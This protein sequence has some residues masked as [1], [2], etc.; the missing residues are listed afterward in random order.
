M[1]KFHLNGN[2]EEVKVDRR[3]IV[4]GGIFVPYYYWTDVCD[5]CKERECNRLK[6]QSK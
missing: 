2:F 6:E 4:C 3:C 5:I 1:T